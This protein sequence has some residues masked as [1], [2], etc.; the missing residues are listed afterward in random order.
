MTTVLDR[1][2]EVDVATARHRP[3]PLRWLGGAVLVLLA[4]Q[5]GWFLTHNDQLEWSVVADYLF[6]ANVLAGLGTSVLLT[7]V[8]MAGGSVLGV[9][10]AMGQSAGFAPVRWVCALY[11]GL[12]R[13]IPP[14]VQLL[15]WFNLAYLLPKLSVG[16]PFGPE[17]GSWPTNDVI[18]PLTAALIGLTL[19][20]SAY[21][22]EI[23]RAGILS[24]DGGQRDAAMAM[25]FTGD[26]AFFRVVLP[27][28]MRVIIP[29]SG[30]QFISLLKGTS[31]VSV[32]AMT[33]LLHAVQSV[34]NQTYQ[35]VPLL[36]V[37]C[38]WYLVV[39][40]ALSF[41]QQRLERRFGRGTAVGR[42]LL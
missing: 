22:A 40:T 21:M 32:I 13:G 2:A 8:A 14:L 29:P 27:Q 11:V 41:G 16:I 12:F 35:I 39:V 25:G 7:V 37:A 26:Q 20:E 10:L 24:V 30:S 17:F 3:R 36:I 15:F 19:H 23:I 9:L 31:L 34:Y 18:T 4:A 42:G 28:A 6:D 33:D 5:V 38:F 1:P